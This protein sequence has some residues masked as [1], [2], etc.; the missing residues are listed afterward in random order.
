[1]F[2]PYERPAQLTAG[3]VEASATARAAAAQTH[4][5]Q[6]QQAV[7]RTVDRQGMAPHRAVER[8]PAC[9]VVVTAETE[10]SRQEST[11]S[12]ASSV[13]P[14]PDDGARVK[15][16]RVKAEAEA[17]GPSK[18]FRSAVEQ[19][20]QARAAASA[21]VPPSAPEDGASRA[22]SAVKP[23]EGAPPA[24][25]ESFVEAFN[26]VR[27][28]SRSDGPTSA[29]ECR[30]DGMCTRDAATEWRVGLRPTASPTMKEDPGAPPPPS[31][32][33]IAAFQSVRGMSIGS[34]AFVWCSPGY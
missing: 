13:K 22:V 18:A 27:G 12:S 6:P 19:L 11:E 25:S 20:Q 30:L 34:D 5:G 17:Y 7:D 16:E 9:P 1:M 2:T 15:T 32:A 10:S 26:R 8:P 23:E 4:D 14:E 33:F 3:A 21:S 28:V 31:E 24:P 29:G